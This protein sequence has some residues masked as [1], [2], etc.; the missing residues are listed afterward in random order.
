MFFVNAN[1]F[2]FTKLPVIGKDYLDPL[3]CVV[4]SFVG[5]TKEPFSHDFECFPA[6]KVERIYFRQYVTMQTFRLVMLG[7]MN[8]IIFGSITICKTFKVSQNIKPS[9]VFCCVINYCKGKNA[10]FANWKTKK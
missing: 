3:W 5:N 8:Y 1:N 6:G 7:A 2:L 10:N 9:F 4:N